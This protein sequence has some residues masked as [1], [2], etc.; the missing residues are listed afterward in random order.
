MND[1]YNIVSNILARKMLE[2][3]VSMPQ[4]LGTE[5]K[6]YAAA[7]ASYLPETIGQQVTEAI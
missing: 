3:K 4:A 7:T 5:L 6:T 2:G 1:R